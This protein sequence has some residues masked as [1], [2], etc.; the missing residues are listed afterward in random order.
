LNDA[1]RIRI[2]G[3]GTGASGTFSIQ[4]IS[5]VVAFSVDNNGFGIFKSAVQLGA[6]ATASN[7]A[8]RADRILTA[9]NGLTG[10]GDLTADRSFAVSF[11]GSG[12]ANTSSRSDHDHNSTYLGINATAADSSKLG[13]VLAA[14]YLRSDTSDTLTGTLTLDG[15]LF[16]TGDNR[17][18]NL[19]GGTT[20]SKNRF[21]IGEQNLY[22]LGMEW[23]AANS[24]NFLGFVNT[25]ITGN[26]TSTLGSINTSTGVFNWTGALQHSGNAVWDAGNFVP[27]QYVKN[28]TAGQSV[29]GNFTIN[30]DGNI[31][32]GATSGTRGNVLLRSGNNVLVQ[33]DTSGTNKQS[34][35][36][37]YID[38]Q[39]NA[40][41]SGNVAV[42]TITVSSSGLVSNLNAN[43]LNGME[44]YQFAKNAIA[45]EIG[46][47]GVYQGLAVTQQ[48]V[49]NM[50]VLVSSGIVYTDSGMRVSFS[51]QSISL[52]AA[53]TSFDRIDM[54]YIQGSAGGANEGKLAVVTGTPASTPV[55]PSVPAGSVKLASVK[56]KQ[57]IGSILNADITSKIDW[58]PLKYYTDGNFY[59]YKPLYLGLSGEINSQDATVVVKK[60]IKGTSFA[61]TI[62][63]AAGSTSATWTHNLALGTSYAISLSSDSPNRHIYWS[64]K[65][66]N[67]IVVNI[68]DTTDVAVNI[69]AVIMA[70]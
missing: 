14:N 32:V 67:S 56:V 16:F 12:I 39:G 33:L 48:T 59:L 25:T 66:T 3:S 4:G 61:K 52:A 62:T 45:Q 54:V 24:V 18:L 44:E 69:D 37:S 43:F 36:K 10:G 23:D 20:N 15:D 13:G 65:A 68:D 49:P 41:F 30:G 57:N 27:T 1:P 55:E 47:Y 19:A 11:A 60:P 50:T 63:I 58:K 28:D 21:I 70:Y 6:P 53:S 2:G 9:G 31:W 7:H 40:Q 5:D 42:N 38:G 64:S 22:G 8:V 51:S 29:N 26:A 46:G 35:V 17:K 34:G